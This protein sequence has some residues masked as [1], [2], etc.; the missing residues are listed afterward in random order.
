MKS[1]YYLFEK[2]SVAMNWLYIYSS[3][4][5]NTLILPLSGI[6]LITIAPTYTFFIS[7]INELSDLNKI[8]IF[9][10]ISDL[11]GLLSILLSYI[12]V[13]QK[14]YTFRNKYNSFIKE[15]K[16]EITNLIPLYENFK[17]SLD[18][19][20]YMTEL[21]E[22]LAGKYIDTFERYS[23]I[24]VFSHKFFTDLNTLI[25][26]KLGLTFAKQ[27]FLEFILFNYKYELYSEFIT[28]E[29]NNEKYL[30]KN[31]E[32]HKILIL[33]S[34]YYTK[35]ENNFEL[36]SIN[37]DDI[38]I[39]NEELLE[40][41][42]EIFIPERSSFYQSLSGKF[43]TNLTNNVLKF[44]INKSYTVLSYDSKNSKI[45]NP[46]LVIKNEEQF[47]SYLEELNEKAKD[48]LRERGEK[49][50]EEI[51]KY[52]IKSEKDLVN[53]KKTPFSY[54]LKNN[55]YIQPALDKNPWSPVY[56]IDPG[57]LPIKFRNDPINYIE[58]IVKKDA[59][60]YQKN[61]NAKIKKLYP[62]IISEKEL[63]FNYEVIPF[64]PVTVEIQARP[65]KIPSSFQNLLV[66]NLILAKDRDVFLKAKVVQIKSII[67]FISP[68]SLIVKS[69][70][71][72]L[73]EKIK[74]IE[75]LFLKELAKPQNNR[76]TWEGTQN[77]I[78]SNKSKIS[79]VLYKIIKKELK[80]KY[81]TQLK[82]KEIVT[83][84][85]VNAEIIGE[86]A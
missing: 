66:T 62:E 27:K 39:K 56:I 72:S 16:I 45:Y 31:S 64:N 15:I 6:F 74:F 73:I 75:P 59:L 9:S 37:I 7:I 71:P 30:D 40:K 26:K 84:I 52:K 48:I 44:A 51:E 57:R 65:D 10:T 70:E 32:Y 4:L 12:L 2:I 20:N 78:G 3:S 76:I 55:Q 22:T 63:I 13:I 17:V 60:N 77:I 49:T 38:N 80:L 23:D 24:S 85:I 14:A 36:F 8:Q 1:I 35:I 11:L 21:S 67:K 47:D 69:I 83:E 46:V 25:S 58:T 19:N 18:A 86:E 33:L 29:K 81:F 79:E 53:F 41:Y 61:L 43:D 68:F 82:C 42:N 50:N 28:I 5:G 34:H 54:A